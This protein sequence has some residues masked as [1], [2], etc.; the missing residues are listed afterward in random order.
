MT[1][2]CGMNCKRRREGQK[3][4]LMGNV[5]RKKRSVRIGKNELL[6]LPSEFYKTFGIV[7]FEGFMQGNPAA[8]PNIVG[9]SSIVK[10]GETG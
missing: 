6:I 8:V 5:Q 4:C 2:L 3:Y 9:F 7:V 1:C 10:D